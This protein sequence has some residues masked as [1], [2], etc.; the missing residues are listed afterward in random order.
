MTARVTPLVG[1]TG[2]T[3]RF[4]S[5]SIMVRA[6]A[7]RPSELP[8]DAAGFIEVTDKGAATP[9]FRGWM[10]RSSPG[11]AIIEHPVY[12]LRITGCQG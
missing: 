1:K 3:L 10:L 7:T 8:A 2:E 6:C 9:V 4:G 5:L 12:D 11:L